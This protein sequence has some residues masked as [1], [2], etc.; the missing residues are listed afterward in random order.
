MPTSL[1]CLQAFLNAENSV[2]VWTCLVRGISKKNKVSQSAPGS[3]V[4]SKE[5][6]IKSFCVPLTF[7]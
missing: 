1:S 5:M 4:V 6:K 2:S 3:R 7:V